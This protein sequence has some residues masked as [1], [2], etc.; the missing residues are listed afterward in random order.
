[1]LQNPGVPWDTEAHPPSA[2]EPY[3][4][5]LL[6]FEQNPRDPTCHG[7]SVDDDFCMGSNPNGTQDIP[8][9]SQ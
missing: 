4:D 3:R 2:R 7:W 5:P 6:E 1:M 9:D 8:I